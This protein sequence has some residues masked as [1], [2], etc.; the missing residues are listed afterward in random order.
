[1]RIHMVVLSVVLAFGVAAASTSA[2][3]TPRIGAACKKGAKTVKRGDRWLG[4]VN[5]GYGKYKWMLMP[6]LTRGSDPYG[7]T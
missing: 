4:C 1:M 7:G 2:A 3:T 6:K 5:H